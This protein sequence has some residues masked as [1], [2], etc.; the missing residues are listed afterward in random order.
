MSTLRK[1][2]R[3]SEESLSKNAHMSRST[4][5]HIEAHESNIRL[6]SIASVANALNL[7]L[8]LLVSP[9]ECKSEL[10]TVGIGFHIIHDGPSSW[11]IHLFNLVDHFRQTLDPRLLLLPPPLALEF[12]FQALI[13]SVVCILCKEAGMDTPQ[14]AKKRYYLE[15]PWFVSE[16]EA[17]KAS[18]LI[19]SPI[20]FRNNNLFVLSNFLER[21]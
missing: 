3:L 1:R 15:K 5:R 10:S 4:L 8:D 18:A 11:K 6:E 14:W 21:A 13:A 9:S 2:Q 7:Q 16:T 12:K 20:Y 17:L 19:E